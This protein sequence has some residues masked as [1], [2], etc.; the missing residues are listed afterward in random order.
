MEA[1]KMHH[2]LARRATATQRLCQILTIAAYVPVHAKYS[3]SYIDPSISLP[4]GGCLW[5]EMSSVNK[6]RRIG[7]RTQPH[8]EHPGYGHDIPGIRSNLTLVTGCIPGPL[9]YVQD[10]SVGDST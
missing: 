2:V 6:I 5:A 9:I 7:E 4:P 8:W 10:S 1:R 3:C